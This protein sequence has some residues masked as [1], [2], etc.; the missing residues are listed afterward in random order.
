MIRLSNLEL[1]ELRRLFSHKGVR[2][3]NFQDTITNVLCLGK[4]F[5]NLVKENNG[6]HEDDVIAKLII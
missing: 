4:S 6:S 3:L 2:Y 1:D 5:L